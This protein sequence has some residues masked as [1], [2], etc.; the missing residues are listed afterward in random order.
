MLLVCIRSCLNSIL[1]YTFLFWIPVIRA[2]CLRE[3]SCENLSLFFESR[4]SARAIKFGK[5]WGRGLAFKGQLWQYQLLESS[6]NVMAHDDARKGKWRGNWWMGWVAS[7]LHTSSE[8]GLAI[9]TTITTAEA[10]TSAA[11]SRLNWRPRR[12]KW[13]RPFRRKKKS[14][15]C[16]CATTFQKQST[17]S[18]SEHPSKG[19]PIICLCRHRGEEEVKLQPVLNLGAR[20]GEWSA[21]CPGRFISGKKPIPKLNTQ[22]R[23]WLCT[24]NAWN[25]SVPVEEPQN[26]GQIC[27]EHCNVNR[28]RSSFLRLEDLKGGRGV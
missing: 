19:P 5:C 16:A 23:L 25:L 24:I 2:F 17:L 15:F 22:V 1:R 27:V 13:T 4:R 7:T 6:W 3:Q 21:L 28:Q 11:G 10:H 14:G 8:H 9:I 26:L 12:F 18:Y 20:R